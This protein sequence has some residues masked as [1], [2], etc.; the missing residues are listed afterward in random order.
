MRTA[1][2]LESQRHALKLTEQKNGIS[3]IDYEARLEFLLRRRTLD[4]FGRISRCVFQAASASRARKTG[5]EVLVE[6][7]EVNVRHS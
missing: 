7:S 2:T 1:R 3:K 4:L 5:D 6:V